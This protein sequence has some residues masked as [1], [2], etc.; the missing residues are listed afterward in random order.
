MGM[1]TQEVLGN[2]QPFMSQVRPKAGD[3]SEKALRRYLELVHETYY[4]RDAL[5]PYDDQ[6][7]IA[8]FGELR[9]R[10]MKEVEDI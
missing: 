5:D 6:A 9:Q 1:A 8:F 2:F 10:A 3:M 7:W 4:D